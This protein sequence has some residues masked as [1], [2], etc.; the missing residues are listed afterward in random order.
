MRK[1]LR[2]IPRFA[3]NAITRNP[4][5]QQTNLLESLREKFPRAF[6]TSRIAQGATQGA[7]T[8]GIKNYG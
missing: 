7:F 3:G 8:A 2:E 1:P 4:P 5:P 6:S